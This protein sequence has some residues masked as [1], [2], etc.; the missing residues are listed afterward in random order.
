LFNG[1]FVLS[2]SIGFI[3]HYLDQQ[4]LQEWLHR[5]SWEDILYVE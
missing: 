4:R 5:T 1:I 3:G 2:R